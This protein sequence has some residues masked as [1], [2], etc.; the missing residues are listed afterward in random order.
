MIVLA[1]CGLAAERPGSGRWAAVRWPVR[2]RRSRSRE[3]R[4]HGRTGPRRRHS[5]A[6]RTMTPRARGAIRRTRDADAVGRSS[7]PADA[8][9]C[10]SASR[11]APVRDLGRRQWRCRRCCTGRSAQGEIPRGAGALRWADRRSPSCFAMRRSSYRGPSWLAFRRRDAFRQGVT[12]GLD[13]QRHVAARRQHPLPMMTFLIDRP[14][15]CLRLR[16]KSSR[17]LT[18]A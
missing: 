3:R 11:P 14:L 8:P 7:L 5:P 6:S 9:S 17:V 13:G 18:P 10:A 1:A 16:T 4:R 15:P 12:L 2:P